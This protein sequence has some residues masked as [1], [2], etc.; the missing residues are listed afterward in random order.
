MDPGM[1]IWGTVL[2]L[3]AI[4]APGLALTFA[5]MP[6]MSD[7]RMAERLGLSLVF[8]ISPY[9]L[10][11]F[12]TKNVNFPITEATTQGTIL[13]ITVAA[14]AVWALRNRTQPKPS[15]HA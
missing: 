5:V 1:I 9:L 3:A 6:K 11:H 14:A 7:V 4:M 8:G 12:L 13:G 10:L 15:T 2:I